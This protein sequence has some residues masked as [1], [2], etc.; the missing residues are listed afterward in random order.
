MSEAKQGAG[1]SERL[2]KSELDVSGR[3]QRCLVILGLLLG[4]AELAQAMDAVR[5][6]GPA[7]YV[8]SAAAKPQPAP[9]RPAPA[10]PT[11][12]SKY[13]FPLFGKQAA[14]RGYNVPLPWGIGINYLFINQQ[15]DISKVA[16]SLNDNPTQEVEFIGFKRVTSTAHTFT[17]RPDLW[18]F[19]FLNVYGIF[20]GA[21]ASTKVEVNEP[22]SFTSLVKQGA[23]T[24]G[25]GVTGTIGYR[26]LFAALD[27]NFTWTKLENLLEPIPGTIVSL[28]LGKNF[29]LG[30]DR[31]LAFWGGA[32]YQAIRATTKGSIA[33]NEALDEDA[34]DG[35]NAAADQ[36]CESSPSPALCNRFMEELRENAPGDTTVNYHLD[37]ELKT[38]LNLILGAQ[39]GFSKSWF[40]RAEAGLIGRYSGLVSASYRF[41]IR[42]R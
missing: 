39:Y 5:V 21:L 35:I 3:A 29:F 14:A 32:M 24:A 42:L 33:L 8:M 6:P 38:P 18:I 19:P 9:S 12:T 22:L 40:L 10:P 36:L 23:T 26:G 27:A 1:R 20:G 37:K 34:I 17:V 2:G 13:V 16:L 30:R 15:I 11:K 41:G 31:S 7:P 25:F 28:R 4:W